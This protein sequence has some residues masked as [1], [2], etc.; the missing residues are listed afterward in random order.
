MVSQAR[1]SAKLPKV[2][3]PLSVATPLMERCYSPSFSVCPSSPRM[4]VLSHSAA[5]QR[6]RRLQPQPAPQGARGGPQPG[7]LGQPGPGGLFNP[8]MPPHMWGPP[9]MVP[10]GMV[11]PQ[12]AAPQNPVYAAEGRNLPHGPPPAENGEGRPEQGER[13]TTFLYHMSCTHTITCL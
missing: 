9:G 5:A 13:L 4:D 6:A 1:N 3:N 12:P 11:P 7:I 2:L 8:M 10:P